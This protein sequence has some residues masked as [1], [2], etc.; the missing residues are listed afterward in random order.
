M[1]LDTQQNASGNGG[2][3]RSGHWVTAL[4]QFFFCIGHHSDVLP[5]EDDYT[6][7]GAGGAA[8]RTFGNPTV[9]VFN[10]LYSLLDI[11]FQCKKTTFSEAQIKQLES[12]IP[13]MVAHLT[14]L[15]E[16]KQGLLC[17]PAN[18][19]MKMR[20]NHAVLH[21]PDTIRMFGGLSKSNA[22][23]FEAG[24]IKFTT[25]IYD[26]VSGRDDTLIAEMIKKV[27]SQ[28]VSINMINVEGIVSQGARLS[29]P[30]CTS[31]MFQRQNI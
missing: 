31:L 13:S 27:M 18:K 30:C 26:R 20:K 6:I 25:G 3:H 16:L 7:P 12:D 22:D 11:Y 15:W 19:R 4:L 23:R 24:H 28:A 1:M 10:L 8:D 21:F 5:N 9:K 2:S 29:I 17:A 14:A